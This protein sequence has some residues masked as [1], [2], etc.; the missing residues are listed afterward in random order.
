MTSLKRDNEKVI[1]LSLLFVIPLTR[2]LPGV[3]MFCFFL[4][5]KALYLNI[6]VYE[7]PTL[8]TK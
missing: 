3:H 5:K 8:K 6:H 1:K 7:L 4:K 2:I